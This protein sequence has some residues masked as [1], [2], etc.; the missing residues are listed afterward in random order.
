MTNFAEDFSDFAIEKKRI[1]KPKNIELW[2][3]TKKGAHESHKFAKK[4]A[5]I[6]VI[7]LLAGNI[8]W[9]SG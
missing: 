4:N 9:L 8:S 7:G 3:E 5:S 2:K 1:W 6:F